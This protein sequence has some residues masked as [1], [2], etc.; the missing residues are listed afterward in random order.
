[1][2]MAASQVRFL[3]L[4]DRKSQI[5][6]RLGILSN[7]KMALTRDQN[8][9]AKAYNEAYS[10]TTLQWYDSINGKYTDITYNAMMTPN[11]GNSY[12]PFIITNRNSGRVILDGVSGVAGL[13][14]HAGLAQNDNYWYNPHTIQMFNE[15][16]DISSMPANHDRSMDYHMKYLTG[17]SGENYMPGSVTYD[18]NLMAP[19][20]IEQ[21][22]GIPNFDRNKM[23]YSGV[24]NT[25]ITNGGYQKLLHS[26]ILGQLNTKIGADTASY[27]NGVVPLWSYSDRHFGNTSP[28]HGYWYNAY[29]DITTGNQ[30]GSCSVAEADS[31]KLSQNNAKRAYIDSSGNAHQLKEGTYWSTLYN[32]GAVILLSN[33]SINDTIDTQVITS[34]GQDNVKPAIKEWAKSF[35]ESINEVGI[36]SQ[37]V[38]ADTIAQKVANI[39]WNAYASTYSDSSCGNVDTTITSDMTNLPDLRDGEHNGS[40]FP[41]DLA[42]HLSEIEYQ[43]YSDR[44]GDP[45]GYGRDNGSTNILSAIAH[46]ANATMSPIKLASG[47]VQTQNVD[48][49]DSLIWY[50]AKNSVAAISLRNMMD[51][52]LHLIEMQLEGQSVDTVDSEFGGWSDFTSGNNPSYLE[53]SNYSQGLMEG[54]VQGETEIPSYY[55]MKSNLEMLYD[56]AEHYRSL[57][58]SVQWL[59]EYVGQ[60][61]EDNQGLYGILKSDLIALMNNDRTYTDL[62]WS[63]LTIG[64]ANIN[65]WM[66]KALEQDC[67]TP[68][69]VNQFNEYLNNAWKALSLI[70]GGCYTENKWE[71]GQGSGFAEGYYYDSGVEWGRRTQY[72]SQSSEDKVAT[73]HLD[74]EGQLTALQLHQFKFYVNLVKE[75]LARGWEAK[76]DVTSETT[77]LHMQ[78]GTWLINDTMAKTSSRIFEVNNKE[79]REEALSKYEALQSELKIKEERIDIQMEKLETEQNAIKTELDSLQNIINDNIKSTFKLFS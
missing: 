17:V 19:Y 27:S 59:G 77:T 33:V 6:M 79:A 42:N 53:P 41:A 64:L 20:I 15:H 60:D 68:G 75:C 31:G 21:M 48:E 7:R 71:Q 35:V 8:K 72:F 65:A 34:G 25:D 9:A 73:K 66:C 69:G 56:K 46:Q 78:N 49:N 50:G 11:A 3:T 57:D 43:V 29:L 28:N 61:S 5:G 47:T 54:F 76:P 32:N 52:A 63:N 22:M 38:D 2:G 23:I 45:I 12:T 18:E 55:S 62:Q 74:I 1:M 58:S 36:F 13:L 44:E 37:V 51:L 39:M 10:Q 14:G 30:F 67:T 4:Q 40:P 26:D 24:Q 70:W 16:S